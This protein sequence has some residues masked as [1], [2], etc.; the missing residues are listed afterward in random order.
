MTINLENRENELKNQLNLEKEEFNHLVSQISVSMDQNQNF[1]EI[2]KQLQQYMNNDHDE[3]TNLR[4]KFQDQENK[5]KNL[6]TQLNQ[7]IYD[8]NQLQV[9]KDKYK[10]QFEIREN[11]LLSQINQSAQQLAELQNQFDDNENKAAEAQNQQHILEEQYNQQ[12]IYLQNQSQQLQQCVHLA[13][14]EYNQLKKTT[15]NQNNQLLKYIY[16]Q[17]NYLQLKLAELQQ[18]QKIISELN[19][20][21]QVEKNFVSE[22]KQKL[23]IEQ[24]TFLQYQITNQNLKNENI[25]LQ[26]QLEEQTRQNIIYKQQYD[27]LKANNDELNSKLQILVEQKNYFTQNM[28]DFVI[29]KFQQNQFGQQN[30]LQIYNQDP[31]QNCCYIQKINTDSQKIVS[32]SNSVQLHIQPFTPI[33]HKQKMMRITTDK[34]SNR[35]AEVDNIICYL[36]QNGLNAEKEKEDVV[37]KFAET[38][39]SLVLEAV[40]NITESLQVQ[41]S[42]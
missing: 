16:E 17:S 6:E 33:S 24:T 31:T 2:S 20:Q 14:S 30:N 26:Q 25:Q 42:E 7:K 27:V 22:L 12:I 18:S 34:I 40:K 21:L 8:Q 15:E 32:E 41:V 5:A 11:E 13:Q 36:K 4:N 19:Q 1:E 28:L 37:I 29:Q 23:Q 35:K 39:R 9:E 3:L 10:V 38:E